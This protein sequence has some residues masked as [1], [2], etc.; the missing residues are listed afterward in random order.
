MDFQTFKSKWEDSCS[1][2]SFGKL[3]EDLD[4]PQLVYINNMIKKLYL[5]N[6]RK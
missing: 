4:Q 2:E 3:Y 5:W 6:L 1:L